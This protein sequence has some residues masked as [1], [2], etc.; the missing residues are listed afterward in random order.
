MLDHLGQLPSE[1]AKKFG[2][3][4]IN[5]RVA[6]LNKTRNIK[7]IPRI[8]KPKVNICDLNRLCNIEG[9][10]VVELSHLME[11]TIIQKNAKA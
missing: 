1:A 9:K 6:F 5:E 10:K 2:T 4:P 11:I 7:K 3:I 8:T